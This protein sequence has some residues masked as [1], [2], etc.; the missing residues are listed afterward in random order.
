M[1]VVRIT[2]I[3][4]VSFAIVVS[5]FRLKPYLVVSHTAPDAHLALV[6]QSLCS[7][8]TEGPRAYARYM[9]SSARAELVTSLHS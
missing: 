3:H 7:R 8:K 5:Q 6:V 4:R 1:F 2:A 9:G